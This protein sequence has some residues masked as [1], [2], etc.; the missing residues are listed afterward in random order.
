MPSF[1][2]S[3]AIHV[4]V[5]SEPA[6]TPGIRFGARCLPISVRMSKPSAF[7]RFRFREDPEGQ[8]GPSEAVVPDRGPSRITRRLFAVVD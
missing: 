6:R 1:E 4:C 2:S 3:G 7:G 8:G 5:V